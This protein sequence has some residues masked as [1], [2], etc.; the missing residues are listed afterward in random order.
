MRAVNHYNQLPDQEVMMRNI[1]D[2]LADGGVFVNQLSSGTSGNCQ[3]RTE[4]VADLPLIYGDTGKNY[5]WTSI[6]ENFLLMKRAGFSE[7]K[8]VGYAKQN[9]WSPEEQWERMNGVL[10]KKA[11]AENNQELLEALDKHHKIYISKA[12]ALIEKYIAEHGIEKLGVEKKGNS[13]IVNY[14]YPIFVSKK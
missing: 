10:L 3:L 8:L 4:L 13:Y 7:T 14:Q 2:N 12:N 1:K 6:E 9:A 5:H 11:Q